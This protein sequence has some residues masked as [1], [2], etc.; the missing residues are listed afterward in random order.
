[1]TVYTDTKAVSCSAVDT[2][3]QPISAIMRLFVRYSVWQ[4]Y[5]PNYH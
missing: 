4:S 1:M 2:R 5:C 3:A